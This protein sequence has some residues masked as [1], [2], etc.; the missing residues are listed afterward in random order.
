MTGALLA[1]AGWSP[2]PL[3]PVVVLI[4]FAV[5]WMIGGIGEDDD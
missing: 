4:A 5:G 1:S 3:L 2:W